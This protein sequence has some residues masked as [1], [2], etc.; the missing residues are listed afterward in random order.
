MNNTDDNIVS[1]LPSYSAQKTISISQKLFCHGGKLEIRPID[2]ILNEIN[3]QRWV[4]G[5]FVNSIDSPKIK[6]YNDSE[7]LFKNDFNQLEYL[8]WVKAIEDNTTICNMENKNVGKGVFVLPKKV[9]PQKTFIPSSGIIKLN[10]TTE[11]LETKI[12]CSALQDLELDKPNIIGFIDPEKMG[13]IL[14]LINHAPDKDELANFDFISPSIQTQIATY[15]LKCL[16]K[17]YNGYAIMGLEV[18]NDIY[19]GEYGNQL[20]WSYAQ[21]WEYI[22]DYSESCKP[23]F[24]FDARERYNGEIIDI[25]SYAL[26]IIDIYIDTG[27]SMIHKVAALTRWELLIS[28]PEKRL[29]VTSQDQSYTIQS[30]IL[31]SYLQFHLQKYPLA[32]RIVLKI[33]L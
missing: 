18:V 5:L 1:L 2:Y 9:L 23:L 33:N 20:L 14:N 17:F 30:P 28:S 7:Q 22:N 3:R 11:E 24:L 10:P 16:T 6:R 31:Y 13:G 32:N 21:P 12:N 26:K 19:G 15:N 8:A 4:E 29:M 27:K 25:N